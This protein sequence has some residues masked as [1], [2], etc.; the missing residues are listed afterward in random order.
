MGGGK[1]IPFKDTP[2]IYS[3]K[4]K[5]SV[6][7]KLEKNEQSPTYALGNGTLMTQRFPQ[8]P[9]DSYGNNENTSRLIFGSREHLQNVH[10]QLTVIQRYCLLPEQPVHYI[11]PKQGK[12]SNKVAK[13]TR[14]KSVKQ[15]EKKMQFTVWYW[16]CYVMTYLKFSHPTWDGV[17]LRDYI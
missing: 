8:A 17:L 16:I 1:N 13:K 14:R 15:L 6:V 7:I 11:S 5:N 12:N 2:K 10:F 3:H 9:S 4:G